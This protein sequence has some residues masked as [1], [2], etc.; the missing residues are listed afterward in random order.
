MRIEFRDFSGSVYG[1]ALAAYDDASGTI[2]VSKSF[3]DAKANRC[4]ELVHSGWLSQPNPLMHELAHA[5]HARASTRSYEASKDISFT[6]E[7]RSIIAEG[8]SRYACE[9]GREFMAEFL[10]GA[11]AGREYS[12][13]VVSIYEFVLGSGATE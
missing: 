3:D 10:S 5:F 4:R 8:V 1:P 9:N 7:Q 11:W 2:F 6:D 12:P 13:E